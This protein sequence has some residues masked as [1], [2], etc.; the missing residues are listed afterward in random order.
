MA[1]CKLQV[2]GYD[3]NNDVRV[4]HGIDGL[5]EIDGDEPSYPHPVTSLNNWT[6]VSAEVEAQKELRENR[7]L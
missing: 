3:N 6:E 4:I 7:K 2:T 5:A 1:N